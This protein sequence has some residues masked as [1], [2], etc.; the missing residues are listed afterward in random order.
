MSNPL[1]P[2]TSEHGLSRFPPVDSTT[3]GEVQV[4]QSSVQGHIWVH[5]SSLEDVDNPTS[6]MLEVNA[7][8][9]LE[10]AGVLR[11]QLSF[12]IDNNV[13]LQLPEDDDDDDV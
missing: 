5:V 8:L 6:D 12:L 9:T 1:E 3:G 4:Y 10:N 2:I 7:L 13:V 11:D